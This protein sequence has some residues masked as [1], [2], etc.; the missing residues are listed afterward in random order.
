MADMD[1]QIT[2]EPGVHATDVLAL[3]ELLP[4]WFGRPAS[5]A[6][7]ALEAESLEAVTARQAGAL[8]GLATL[9]AAT[10]FST[11]LPR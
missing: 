6:A 1:A 9:K 2:V 4:E 11:P 3:L 7:Y 8:V 5:S 10:A